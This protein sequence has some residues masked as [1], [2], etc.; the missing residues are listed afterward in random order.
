MAPQILAAC[1][2]LLGLPETT[3]HGQRVA[4]ERDRPVAGQANRGHG[5]GAQPVVRQSR[6]RPVHTR[7]VG[8]SRRY[9]VH[10]RAEQRDGEPGRKRFVFGHRS[11]AKRRGHL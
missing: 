1:F 11:R 10:V 8:R 3:G 5:E 9:A 2:Q 6:V 4:G 7:P